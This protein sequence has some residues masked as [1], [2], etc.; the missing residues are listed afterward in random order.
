MTSTNKTS[1]TPPRIA[2]L[3][4]G[5]RGTADPVAALQNKPLKAFVEIGGEAMID[6]VLSALKDSGAFGK[7]LVCIPEVDYKPHA[8]LMAKLVKDGTVELITPAAS[9]ASSVLK[10]LDHTPPDTPLLVT[11]A[12]HPL[13]TADIIT[14]FLTQAAPRAEACVAMVPLSLIQNKYP[15]S[16]RTRL[17]FKNGSFSGCNLFLLKGESVRRL[18]TFWQTLETQRKKPQRMALSIG[19]IAL[20]G[21]IF[22]LLTLENILSII[23]KKTKTKI[24]AVML[25]TPEAG[26]DVDKTEDYELVKTIMEGG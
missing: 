3:L 21:Y 6:H 15:Q 16:R 19:P 4:A 17:R 8:P 23:A 7:I 26:I 13:L 20:I 14:R 12:D 25:D 11:T 24:E 5:S 18:I 2:C 22:N 1:N 10:I 9:P